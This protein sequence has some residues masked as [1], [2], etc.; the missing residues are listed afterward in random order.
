MAAVPQ[1]TK[2]EISTQLAILDVAVQTWWDAAPAFDAGFAADELLIKVLTAAYMAQ[3]AKNTAANTATA[4]NSG[5]ALASFAAPVN[6]VPV[7]DLP[8][9][10]QIFT[11]AVTVTGNTSTDSNRTVPSR[12]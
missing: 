11:Q 1:V 10:L 9:G 4:L 6:G 7:L 5:E 12:V 2:T 3:V 8:T